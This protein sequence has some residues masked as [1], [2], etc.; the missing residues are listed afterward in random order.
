MKNIF[1]DPYRGVLAPLLAVTPSWIGS[2]AVYGSV[3]KVCVRVCALSV[4]LSIRAHID[5][6]RAQI[7]ALCRVEQFG[8]Q[9]VCA[10]TFKLVPPLC[11][12]CKSK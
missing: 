5:P 11:I 4:S 3:L 6:T 12:K 1:R 10:T 2:Y 8:L 9:G 7:K